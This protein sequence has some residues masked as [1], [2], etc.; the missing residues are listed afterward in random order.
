MGATEPSA[1]QHAK[2]G[3]G[4]GVAGGGSSVDGKRCAER[5]LHA[6][7]AAEDIGHLGVR[8]TVRQNDAPDGSGG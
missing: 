3:P 5:L 8:A 6:R 7:Q 1:W 2:A 4:S